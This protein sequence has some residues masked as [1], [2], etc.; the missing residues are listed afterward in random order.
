M[1]ARNMSSRI[2][3]VR[4][5][6]PSV[7][8]WY[9]VLNFRWVPKFSWRL[10]QKCDRNLVS[11]SDTMLTGTPCRRTISFIY[12]S[13][14]TSVDWPTLK[15]R[16]WAAF[17]GRSMITYIA[18]LPLGLRGSAVTKSMVICSHFH[19]GIGNVVEVQ[20]FSD[21]LYLQVNQALCHILG[22]LSS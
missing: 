21:V 1:Q 5:D 8:G 11:L 19:S 3:I 4:S 13:V 7:W 18:L 2:W 15:G 17:V 14:R 9:E 20:L 12:L 22:Y 10:F 16:K 6:C